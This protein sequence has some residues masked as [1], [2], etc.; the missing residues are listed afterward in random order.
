MSSDKTPKKRKREEEEE[1]EGEEE[2]ERKHKKPRL[3]KKMNIPKEFINK[4]NNELITKIFD[5]SN[6]CKINFKYDGRIIQYPIK[7][8]CLSNREINILENFL[9]KGQLFKESQEFIEVLYCLNY[10]GAKELDKIVIENKLKLID[11]H[12][13]IENQESMD[14]FTTEAVQHVKSAIEFYKKIISDGKIIVDCSR[15][16]T[17]HVNLFVQD[18]RNSTIS[19]NIVRTMKNIQLLNICKN[20]KI[21]NDNIVLDITKII[22]KNLTKYIQVLEHRYPIIINYVLSILSSL[23]H[24][25]KLLRYIEKEEFS[26]DNDDEK[27]EDSCKNRFIDVIDV[28]NDNRMFKKFKKIFVLDEKNDLKINKKDEKLHP[29]TYIIKNKMK[30]KILFNRWSYSRYFGNLQSN[31]TIAFNEIAEN[32]KNFIETQVK[33]SDPSIKLTSTITIINSYE[34]RFILRNMRFLELDGYRSKNVRFVSYKQKKD[35]EEE[36]EDEEDEEELYYE[37]I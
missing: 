36:E 24:N 15:E 9:V 17:R 27:N 28:D 21:F 2:E 33:F 29:I 12:A 26:R 3:E 37:M 22:K 1:E 25:Q 34:R 23:I 20:E 31:E 19:T 16:F 4:L 7:N 32:F 8:L 10:E 13:I 6:E 11:T 30:L 14:H 18:K 5:F 35:Q